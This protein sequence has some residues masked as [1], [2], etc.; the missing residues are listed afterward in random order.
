MISRREFL[1]DAAAV[2]ASGT[3]LGRVAKTASAKPL[4]HGKKKPNLLFIQP[5][6]FRIQALGIWNQPAYRDAL[7]TVSDP[8]H[9]PELDRLAKEGL[10][11]TCANGT[12]PV[13]SPSRAMLM[14]GMYPSK[15]GVM[16]GNCYQGRPQG[17]HDSITCLTDVLAAS[18]YETALV[19][20]THWERTQALFDKDGNYVGKLT[21]PGGHYVNPYDTY[22]P[23]GAGRHSIKYWYQTIHDTPF[24]PLAFSN[25]PALVGEKKDGEAYQT[26]G[27]S[28]RNEAD[29]VVEYLK[30]KSGQR[31]PNRPFSMMWE[32]IPPHPPY[33][34]LKD[35]ESDVYDK[36]Y[37]NMPLSQLLNRP[38]VGAAKSKTGI[39]IELAARIYF[40]NVTSIDQQ[41]GRV[42]QALEESGEAENTIVIF[43]SDHGEMM[44]SEGLTGKSVIYDEAFLVPLTIRFPNR[45]KAGLEDLMFSKVDFMPTLLGMMGLED[46]IPSTVRGINYSAGLLTGDYAS[47]PKPKSAVY[48]MYD[49]RGVR[50]DRYSYQVDKDGKT[51]LFDNVV[52]P[53]QMKN[54]SPSSIDAADLRTLK[55]E[56][57]EWLKTATDPWYD[58]RMHSE[59]IEYPS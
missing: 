48:M 27:Y 19:G 33:K 38:N 18:D 37:K 30:N 50:T 56:L 26:T 23:P 39:D 35:C 15:N 57:G 4:T 9:T 6:E 41:L 17:L 14:S 25:V 21:P 45:L 31:D 44:G 10:L 59:S 8:V 34:S 5:D 28:P 29:V 36:Y 55:Q 3:L 49:G 32:P 47:Q 40:S 1:A 51:L 11:F 13:C 54:L 43:T 16:D 58:T 22:I 52:D 24:N 46:R 7:K 20:K 53:Y 42:L 2:A 12:S